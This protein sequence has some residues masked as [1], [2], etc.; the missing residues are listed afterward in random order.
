MHSRL[1]KDVV[2]FWLG[3][4]LS[5]APPKK[6]IRPVLPN[7]HSLCWVATNFSYHYNSVLLQKAK[8][9][10]ILCLVLVICT[11][12]VNM[13]EL[14]R[15]P[16][17]QKYLAI[18]CHQQYYHCANCAFS[19]SSSCLWSQVLCCRHHPKN[20]PPEATNNACQ[21]MNY[22]LP[23]LKSTK[24][25]DNH[26][27]KKM[28]KMIQ[29]KVLNLQEPQPGGGVSNYACLESREC[30]S[31]CLENSQSALVPCSLLRL[32]TPLWFKSTDWQRHQPVKDIRYCC[33]F[34]SI[35]M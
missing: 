14:R 6:I 2:R 26:C 30:G 8:N 7:I 34:T 1:C 3:E 15:R 19:V 10:L 25:F 27:C 12:I 29:S 13:Q 24:K 32:P 35:N 4:V 17:L 23:A 20:C 11:S 9:T 18:V 31:T 33:T 21:R 28:I 16:G 22:R 5:Q